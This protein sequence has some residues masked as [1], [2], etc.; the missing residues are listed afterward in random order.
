G[1]LEIGGMIGDRPWSATLDLAAAAP[2][3]GVSKLWARR[4]IDDA[5]VARA[6]REATPEAAD[7]EIV[8]IAL[9][10]QLATRLTSLVAVDQ[11]PRRPEGARLTRADVP[12][13]LP[14]GWDFDMVFGPKSGGE[15]DLEQDPAAPP[16][17]RA[18]ASGAQRIALAGVAASPTPIVSAAPVGGALLPATATDAELR[19]YVGFA[20]VLFAV[21]LLI[22]RPARRRRPA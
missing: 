6:L 8:R 3:A 11:T 5:E 9:E 16:L 7:A 19:R 21:G 15:R 12:L 2:G 20:L 14:A 4:K 17:R 13:N 10:H 22:I 1:P 18:D